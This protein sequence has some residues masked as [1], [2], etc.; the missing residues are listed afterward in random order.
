MVLTTTTLND[1]YALLGV[2]STATDDEI[3]KAYRKKALQFHPDKNSSTTAEETFK[4]INKAYEILGDADKRRT[5][6]LQQ[7]KSS[8]HSNSSSFPSASRSEFPF[9]SSDPFRDVRQRHARFGSAFRSSKFADHDLFNPFRS[10]AWPFE[11]NPFMMFEML[12]R[13]VFDQ[14]LHDDLFWHHPSTSTRLR[15]SSQHPRP[16]SHQHRTNIPVNHVQPRKARRPTSAFKTRESD[17]ENLDEHFVFQQKK[18]SSQRR[19]ASTDEKLHTCQYCFYPLTSMTNLFKHESSCRH[20]PAA[21]G[22][23]EEKFYTSKC[24]HCRQQIRLSDYLEHENLCQQTFSK[25]INVDKSKGNSRSRCGRGKNV[26][27]RLGSFADD[28]ERLRTCQRCERTFPVLSELF[29]HSC[30]E[31]KSSRFH[32]LLSPASRADPS[33]FKRP[34]FQANLDATNDD[35]RRRYASS[36]Y[37][38]LRPPAPSSSSIHVTS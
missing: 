20:R 38:Y 10:S 34:L 28:L 32:Q 29:N 27:V 11:E 5:Y 7:Q 37:V 18:P 2:K 6:D 17:D 30:E 24:S 16:A 9:G 35:Q 13:A 1:Y 33:L 36:D 12:T 25:K 22:S 23:G 15:S 21:G 8:S 26:F 14:F 3:R 19:Y 4:E 31:S